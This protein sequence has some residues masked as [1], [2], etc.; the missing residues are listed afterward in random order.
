MKTNVVKCEAKASVET[1]VTRIKKTF[2]T[3][4]RKKRNKKNAEKIFLEQ[5][6][7]RHIGLHSQSHEN[8]SSAKLSPNNIWQ[9]AYIN[10][11]RWQC[12]Q[13]VRFW[14]NMAMKYRTENTELKRQL[15]QR[16]DAKETSPIKEAETQET[17]DTV[18]EQFISFLEIT[19][20]H[21]MERYSQ[22]VLEGRDSD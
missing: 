9:N 20:K 21:R 4:R 2:A 17:N 1:K 19:A 22:R 12:E 5:R 8:Q 18:D 10:A 6:R 13:Q 16:S 15:E 7:G 14:K 3:K 11:I